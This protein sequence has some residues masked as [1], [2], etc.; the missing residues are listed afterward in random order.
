MR[1]LHHRLTPCRALLSIQAG[2]FARPLELDPPGPCNGDDYHGGAWVSRFFF[3]NLVREVLWIINCD[4]FDLLCLNC[5]SEGLQTRR[6]YCMGEIVSVWP[7]GDTYSNTRSPVALPTPSWYDPHH[8]VTH[9]H[10]SHKKINFLG[11]IQCFAGPRASKT[12]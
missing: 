5:G 6:K 8:Q 11:S 3:C 2:P 1:C 4:W 12:I 10:A 9:P 7:T